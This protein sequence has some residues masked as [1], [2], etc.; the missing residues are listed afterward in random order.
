[1]PT[2]AQLLIAARVRDYRIAKNITVEDMATHLRMS[3]HT[4]RKIESGVKQLYTN[5]LKRLCE[6]FQVEPGDIDS[7]FKNTKYNIHQENNTV[8]D[9]GTANGGMGIVVN[10]HNFEAERRV[11]EELDKAH[12]TT[13]AAQT[14]TIEAL[15]NTIEALKMALKS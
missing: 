13:I 12:K 2:P 8:Q 14:A 15:Q 3:A 5:E 11:W 1:M 6:V 10:D 7:D 4:Y 9:S